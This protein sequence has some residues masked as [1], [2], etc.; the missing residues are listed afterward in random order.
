[1]IKP[2]AIYLPQFHTIPE[3]DK[4]WGDGFTEWT[5]VRKAQPLFDNH[6]QPHVPHEDVGYYDLRDPEVLVRQAAMAKEYG[7]YGFAYYHYWFNGKR[8]L[9][10]PLD[11]MLQSGKPD[12]P[13]LYIWANEN[14]TKRWDGSENNIIIEQHYSKEDDLEHIRF[15]CQN[16]FSDKRYITIDDKPVFI[17][18]RT[19][20]L[21]DIKETVRVWREEVRKFGFKDLYLIRVENFRDDINPLEIGFDA[22]MEFAPDGKKSPFVVDI[23]RENAI[24]DYP[25]SINK[26][27]LKVDRDFSWFR[28]V[29]NGWD[30]SSRKSINAGIFIN[31]TPELFKQ[32][33]YRMV[34]YTK[35]VLPEEQQFIF[36]NAWNEWA[37]GCHLEPDKK[38]GYAYLNAMRDV[39]VDKSKSDKLDYYRFIETNLSKTLKINRQLN[40]E[41]AQVQLKCK[42]VIGSRGH[43]LMSRFILFY[44]KVKK[45]FKFTV[46]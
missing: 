46:K 44:R 28:C 38:S 19:E 20:L 37:E 1:M 11:N 5:N 8:L 36:M 27:S 15:L 21:P 43:Q 35:R 34:Q 31:N 3:N 18:Y 23:I 39:I 12:F 10:T 7:I 45:R 6:Y 13:F 22:A 2:I 40:D 29:Y 30:N 25:A 9:E 14:W 4:A 26:R 42:E 17:V 33:F 41:L 24:I 16:V 32:Y